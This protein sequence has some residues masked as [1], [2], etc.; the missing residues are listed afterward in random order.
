MGY[1][2]ICHKD[3]IA[4]SCLACPECGNQGD[5]WFVETGQKSSDE[6]Q[7]CNGTGKELKCH[8]CNGEGTYLASGNGK[9]ACKYICR[10]CGG[11]GKPRKRYLLGA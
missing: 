10:D 8:I 6:C 2:P 4:L 1:C 11:T 5:G 7:K 3:P 9:V